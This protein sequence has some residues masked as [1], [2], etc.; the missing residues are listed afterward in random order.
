MNAKESKRE[1]DLEEGK[2]ER[3]ILEA[4]ERFNSILPGDFLWRVK[5]KFL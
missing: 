3:E 5:P 1:D 4:L 2:K